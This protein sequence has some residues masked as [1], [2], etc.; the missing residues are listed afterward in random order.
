MC[1]IFGSVGGPAW[2][3]SLDHERAIASMAHR[4]PDGSGMWRSSSLDEP[5]GRT[6][7]ACVLGHTR[8]SIIDLSDAAAQP[9][10][11]V[12]GRYALV[13]NG[14]VYNFAE[15]RREL[16]GFGES[17]TSSGDSEVVLK[18]LVRW[19][20]V[21]VERFRGMFALGL[22]D[23]TDRKLLL[24]RDRLGVKPLYVASKPDGLAFASEVRTLLAAGAAERVL[25]PRGLLGYL[26]F[27][28]VQ[29]PD[30]LV[31]G[32][33][34]LEPGTTLVFDGRETR[35]RRFWRLPTGPSR[36][37]PR[38]EA[39][40]EIRRLLHESV[41][42]RLISDVP[43]GVFLS[44]GGDSSALAA[45]ASAEA[46]RPVHTFTV[47]FDEAAFSEEKH[48]EAVAK[49]FNCV[50]HSV[51]VT[52]DDAA[53]SFPE[54][55]RSQDQPSGD[56]LNTW[57]VSRAARCEG[58]SMTLSGLGGDEVFAGYP[59]FRQFER[60]VKL[61][62]AAAFVPGAFLSFLAGCA[63][64]PS[65]SHRMRK[66]VDVAQAA[67]DPAGVYTALRSHLT[68]RQIEGLIPEPAF[69][70]VARNEGPRISAAMSGDAVNDF[71]RL[72]L[73][74]Y[75]RNTLLRDTD[76][77]SMAS[78]LEVRVPFLDHKLVEY[79][80]SLSGGMKL[81]GEGNKALLF[82][83]VPELPREAGLRP[84]MGFVLP[85]GAWFRG[86]M[87][88]KLEEILLGLPGPATGILRHEPTVEAWRAFLDGDGTVSASRIFGLASLSAWVAENDL[89]LP[90]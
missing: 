3:A 7:P 78:S 44:G 62:G 13:Y 16:E 88:G 72:D 79:V 8:L 5:A 38:A 76:T 81:E 33:R 39:V 34:S 11:T 37:V 28:A 64:R 46:S 32:V 24:A 23:E 47:V 9:M 18:A 26:R 49:R 15:I 56:G 19:G 27:G 66:G 36:V 17:F 12:D 69:R 86:P 4:G 84:K 50:H 22:W 63:A 80:L 41:R 68:D 61:S 73:A 14:E 60:L 20:P 70:R 83:A 6:P 25:S 85:L 54:A 42:M 59:N 58:L 21:A 74:G 29:E 40:G 82:E 52:G 65:A 51:P 30:T 57:L 35:E 75:L 1:G 67:G 77:M 43:F 89:E 87:K 90:W 2:V 10:T 31:A 55:L 71:S 48:A 53:A 45:L